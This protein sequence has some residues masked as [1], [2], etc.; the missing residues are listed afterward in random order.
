MGPPTVRSTV[1]SRGGL[2]T[3]LEGCMDDVELQDGFR[4]ATKGGA[5]RG[6]HGLL[7]QHLGQLIVEGSLGPEDHLPPEEEFSGQFGVSRTV[8][9]EAM[10]VLAA[11]GLV[12]SRP[13]TGTRVLPRESWS[14]L[15][16]EVLVWQQTAGPKPLFLK[17]FE[18][19]RI[20]LE[21][22]GARLAA[23]RASTDQ[24]ARVERALQRM[25]TASASNNRL[26]FVEADVDFHAAIFEACQNQ[27]LR[28]MGKTV[29]TFL[30]IRHQG[31]EDIPDVLEATAP[32]HAAVLAALKSGDAE[33]A[34]QAMVVLVSRAAQDDRYIGQTSMHN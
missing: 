21:P 13:K 23:E 33:R 4:A 20:A 17:E 15:D 30:R 25:E 5:S 32:E 28:Q 2:D 1:P 9:R 10:R 34:Y 8:L 31:L 22:E 29:T 6:L 24:L 16:P 3:Q 18:E 12:E 26:A 27:L 14:L 11:K 19:V 7:V